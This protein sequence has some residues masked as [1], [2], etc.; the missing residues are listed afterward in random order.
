MIFIVEL[1]IL[2]INI[3]NDLEDTT[4]TFIIEAQNRNKCEEK[5]DHLIISFNLP[6]TNIVQVLSIKQQILNQMGIGE[7]T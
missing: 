7:V 3:L 1:R 4:R 6:D 5:I 2:A